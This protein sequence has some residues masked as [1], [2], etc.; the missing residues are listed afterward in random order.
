MKQIKYPNT[1]LFRISLMAIFLLFSSATVQGSLL[2]GVDSEAKIK[3]AI[4]TFATE[5]EVDLSEFQSLKQNEAGSKYMGQFEAAKEIFIDITKRR[6]GMIEAMTL[7]QKE[8]EAN[9]LAVSR[10]LSIDLSDHKGHPHDFQ[11]TLSWDMLLMKLTFLPKSLPGL[12]ESLAEAFQAHKVLKVKRL[13]NA[14]SSL[15]VQALRTTDAFTSINA[16]YVK[17]VALVPEDV[18]GDDL[19]T[20]K[21]KVYDFEQAVLDYDLELLKA[22]KWQQTFNAHHKKYVLL[23]AEQERLAS[24]FKVLE[25]ANDANP[26]LEDIGDLADIADEGDLVKL[27]EALDDIVEA[28]RILTEALVEAKKWQQTFAEHEKQYVLLAAEQQRLKTAF[29]L[30]RE[31][32]DQ[33]PNLKVVD[34]LDE[35]AGE[36]NLVTIK[37]TLED[38]VEAQ[39]VLNEALVLAKAWK[40]VE[41]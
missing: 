22:K 15:A 3:Y 38:I 28:Q 16:L 14:Y 7:M 10:L 25:E 41:L 17:P 37:G 11:P 1:I 35:I 18:S 9:E 31:A 30:L 24:A 39:R 32:N 8:E 4:D 13:K 5:L 29:Q 20:L 26:H 34:D 33:N 6:N 40:P 12:G 27:Q 21:Q 36:G 23:T 19:E 2:E